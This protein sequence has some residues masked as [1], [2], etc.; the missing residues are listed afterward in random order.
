M[1]KH[2]FG[3][4]VYDVKSLGLSSMFSVPNDVLKLFLFPTENC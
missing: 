3:K 4:V 2:K 1:K